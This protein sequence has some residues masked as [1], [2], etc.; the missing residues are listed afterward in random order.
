MSEPKY[1]VVEASSI[2]MEDGAKQL[3]SSPEVRRRCSPTAA[4]SK[5]QYSVATLTLRF[6]RAPICL[7]II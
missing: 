4:T 1:K 3:L 7:A 6:E 2:K 5:R